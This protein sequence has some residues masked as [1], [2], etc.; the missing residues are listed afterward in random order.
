[1][2]PQNTTPGIVRLDASSSTRRH[3]KPR[4]ALLRIVWLT[5]WRVFWARMPPGGE[6]AQL[7][8]PP[9]QPIRCWNGEVSLE[10]PRQGARGID[11]DGCSLNS[12]HGETPATGLGPLWS[13]GVQ[14]RL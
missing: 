7:S 14:H 4:L 12:K 6:C 9:G 1:M 11:E 5:I 10:Y 2:K 8:L 3:C 13:G